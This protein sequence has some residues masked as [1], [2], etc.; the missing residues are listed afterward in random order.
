MCKV[1]LRS[2]RWACSLQWHHNGRSRWRPKSPAPGLFTQPFIQ[3]Q[4]KEKI[5]APRHWPLCGD[6]TGDR[7]IPRTNGQYREKCFHLMTSSCDSL[8]PLT[9]LLRTRCVKLPY[10]FPS[11]LKPWMAWYIAKQTQILKCILGSTRH[12]IFLRDL[13]E[14]VIL[15]AVCWPDSQH[16]EIQKFVLPVNTN[17]AIARSDVCRMTIQYYPQRS[18]LLSYLRLPLNTKPACQF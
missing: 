4:I 13:R 16:S 15:N 14:S 9:H 5:K 6:V 2:R 11:D 18:R 10:S 3:A 12:V 1:Q 8:K 7:W 17:Y